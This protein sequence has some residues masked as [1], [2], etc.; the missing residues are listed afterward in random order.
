MY[1]TGAASDDLTRALDIKARVFVP[2][3]PIFWRSNL[4][5]GTSSATPMTIEGSTHN[6]DSVAVP[7]TPEDASF[8]L[9]PTPAG[10]K[11]H[12]WHELGTPGYKVRKSHF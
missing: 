3:P 8:K 9:I 11:Q 2:V 5:E 12:L 6:A 7:R 4:G 1:G 10:R